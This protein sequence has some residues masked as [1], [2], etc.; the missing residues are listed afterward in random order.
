MPAMESRESVLSV[1]ECIVNEASTKLIM[2]RGPS[3]VGKSTVARV[4]MERTLRPTYL[5]ELDYYRFGFVNPPKRNHG[6]E[7]E[8]SGNDTITA[9]SLGFD[10]VFDGNFTS[11]PDDPFVEKLFRA[12]P[13]ENYLF[14]LDASLP[15]T[16]RR[17]ESKS[18]P[19]ITVDKMKEVYKY[20]YPTGRK[21]EVVIPESSSLEQTVEQIVRIT[22]IC[23]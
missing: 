18:S 14:Y 16:L 4:L 6:L 10:V 9:L 19:R 22:G 23:R 12:H 3:A 11:H 1:H 13:K 5:V 17:H 21:G 20:A 7:Y 8:L 15:E 2:L